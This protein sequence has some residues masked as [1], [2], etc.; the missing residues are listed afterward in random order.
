MLQGVKGQGEGPSRLEGR[1]SARYMLG[2]R[3]M[4]FC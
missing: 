1:S 3:D 4:L 2:V